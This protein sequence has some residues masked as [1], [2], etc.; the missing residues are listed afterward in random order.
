METKLTN[1][2]EVLTVDQM[3]EILHI[4]KFKAYELL[5]THTVR[6]MRI[7][8]K[9]IIPRASIEEFLDNIIQGI[10]AD[11]VAGNKE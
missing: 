1:Y 7:G 9:F 11:L 6:C 5:K 4:G 8:K 3:C 10:V 2:P